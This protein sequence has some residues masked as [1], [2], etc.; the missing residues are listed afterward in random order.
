MLTKDIRR[1]MNTLPNA[2]LAHVHIIRVA[3]KQAIDVHI[4][5]CFLFFFHDQ[6]HVHV[7]N[8]KRI[9]KE[10]YQM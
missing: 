9:L 6:V 2:L 7:R 4:F 10:I 3:T 8:L 1:Q 5:A